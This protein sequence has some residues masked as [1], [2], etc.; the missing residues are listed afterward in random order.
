MVGLEKEVELG[1]AGGRSAGKRA[2]DMELRNK[3]MVEEAERGT[4]LSPFIDNKGLHF[5]EHLRGSRFP[6]CGWC[7]LDQRRTTRS[8]FTCSGCTMAT[9]W[10]RA[11]ANS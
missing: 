7:R 8:T 2:E 10:R 3:K 6:Q 5:S 4:S 1:M 11:I 9:R